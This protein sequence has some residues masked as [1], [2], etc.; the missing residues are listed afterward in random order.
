MCISDVTRV[1]ETRQREGLGWD[2][3]M[4]VTVFPSGADATGAL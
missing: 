2:S 1:T 4:D 3:G